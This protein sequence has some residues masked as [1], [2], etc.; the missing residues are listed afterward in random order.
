[1]RMEKARVILFT[2]WLALFVGYTM[3]FLMTSYKSGVTFEQASESSW[4]IIYVL[5]PILSAFA[6]FWFLPHLQATPQEQQQQRDEVVDSTRAY[7]IFAVTGA[8]HVIVFGYFAIGV[9]FVDFG[10]PDQLISYSDR[11]DTGM[12]IL[13]FLSSFVVLPVGFVLKGKAPERLELPA[14]GA[15]GS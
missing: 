9:L 1:M 13:V 10:Y 15:A 11:V 8:V 14:E 2:I 5:L 6:S 7:A 4:K 3:M 12:R